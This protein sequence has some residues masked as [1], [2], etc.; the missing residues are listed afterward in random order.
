MAVKSGG[1]A[2][3][4]KASKMIKA[5]FTHFGRLPSRAQD[6]AHPRLR[7]PGAVTRIRVML[8]PTANR[9]LPGH[10]IRL[11]IAASNFPKFDV[12][13]QSGE[14]EGEGRL[15]RVACI[16]LFTDTARPSRVLL[17]IL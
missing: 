5:D 10:R 9:F 3:A 1:A 8:M 13:P 16:T 6:H 12:N 2:L 11:D 15:K 14:N 4:D 17:P 7:T